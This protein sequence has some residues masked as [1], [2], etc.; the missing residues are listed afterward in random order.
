MEQ[1]FELYGIPETFHP[2]LAAV[3]A[4]YYELS[5]LYHP[6]RYAQAGN[7]K[8]LEV[9][10]LA[11]QN[12]KA[13][14]TLSNPDATMAYVLRLNG[15]MEDDEKYALPADFLME[16]MDLNEAVTDYEDRPEDTAA[17]ETVVQALK[18]LFE[19]WHQAAE[20]LTRRFD[21]GE[22]NKD[23]LLQIKD[24]YFRKKYL[25]RIQERIDKFA[26]R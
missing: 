8:M 20:T 24:M 13:W 17:K 5:R 6:D 7:T 11:A 12:N 25:L 2:E 9:L 19:E 3:K 26:A 21:G 22:K 15:M 1:F 16:M 10:T 23:L 14:K 4:K 18:T